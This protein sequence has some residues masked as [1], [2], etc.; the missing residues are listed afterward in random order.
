MSTRSLKRLADKIAVSNR[1]AALDA[2]RTAR[3]EAK[4]ALVGELM[5]VCYLVAELAN[6]VEAIGYP[7]KIRF[8][9][10]CQKAEAAIAK[11]EGKQP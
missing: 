2:E 9:V 4:A 6:D 5:A 10:A 3:L 1:V 8:R 7:L 11:A